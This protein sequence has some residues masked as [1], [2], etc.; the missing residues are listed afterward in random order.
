MN[1]LISKLSIRALTTLFGLRF[2]SHTI[3]LLHE[4]AIDAS[5]LNRFL[6]FYLKNRDAFPILLNSYQAFQDADSSP[7]GSSHAL[8]SENDALSSFFNMVVQ[9][10]QSNIA[11]DDMSVGRLVFSQEGEDVLLSRIFTNKKEGFFVDIGAHHPKRFSNTF[12][13]YQL[14]WRGINI[15]PNQ[16]VKRLFETIRPNDINLGIAI[17]KDESEGI[18]YM[19]EEP[20]LNTFNREIAEQYVRSGQKLID[21]KT[22]KTR[23]LSSVLDEYANNHA[24]DLMSIDVEG[25]EM[26]VLES[27]DW[28]KYRPQILLVEI[29][30]F[31]IN[32]ARE[33]PVH[34]L[35]MTK[36]YRMWAKTYNTI[37]YKDNI[38]NM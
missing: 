17:G 21:K 36:G 9:A 22:I 38:S 12:L 1:K 10:R 23:R 19:F 29:L 18:F 35:L 33:F 14:G 11:P 15:E 2:D 6:D 16:D 34:N 25:F 27:N 31:D 4:T 5:E 13:F 32:R 24:I 37:F 20:A 26:P 7:K 8:L 28:D 30:D 3:T